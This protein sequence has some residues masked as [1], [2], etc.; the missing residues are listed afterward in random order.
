MRILALFAFTT[1]AGYIVADS[2]VDATRGCVAQ[3]SQKAGGEDNC[4]FCLNCGHGVALLAV[5]PTDLAP[6]AWL[7]CG[8]F[9][10]M[11]D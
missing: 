7:E 10:P 11:D 9:A 3:S 6:Q 1:F 8:R 5:G 4:T 2:I